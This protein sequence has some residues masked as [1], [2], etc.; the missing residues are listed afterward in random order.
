MSSH[1]GV[2][3]LG[4]MRDFDSRAVKRTG[5]RPVTSA[6]CSCWSVR[7]FGSTFPARKTNRD[8][9]VKGRAVVSTQP[10]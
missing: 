1:W 7:V 5:S 3:E 2:M 6:K 9:Y 4:D 10:M 8:D